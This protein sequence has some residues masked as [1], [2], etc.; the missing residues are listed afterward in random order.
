MNLDVI[1][2]ETEAYYRLVQEI[3]E[4]VQE[5]EKVEELW[6]NGERAREILNIGKTSLQSLRNNQEIIFSQPSRKTILYLVS[7]LY[8]YLE[9]N[10]ANY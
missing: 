5:K 4:M 6:C 10:I 9:K 3:V 7:S 8:E 1:C 2:L